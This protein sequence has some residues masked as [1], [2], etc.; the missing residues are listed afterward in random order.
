MINRKGPFGCFAIETLSENE[1]V[2]EYAMA[3]IGSNDSGCFLPCL[4]N[5]YGDIRELSFDYSGM[6]PI[7]EF[8]STG[9][10]DNK[11]PNIPS[12]GRKLGQR[13]KAVGNLLIQLITI[14][15]K[16]LPPEGLVL[17]P[18]NLYTDKDGIILKSCYRPLE[19]RMSSM[20]LSAVDINDMER[21]INTGF[22][23]DVL[24]EDEK[25][26]LLHAVATGDEDLYL[27]CCR[28]IRTTSAMRPHKD[29]LSIR[30]D[31]IIPSLTVI[32]AVYSYVSIGRK[33]AVLFA[34]AGLI[35][36]FRVI[37]LDRKDKGTKTISKQDQGQLRRKILF[38]PETTGKA[39]DNAKDL[40]YDIHY[41]SIRSVN[42]EDPDKTKS[43]SI[44]TDKV[45][46]GSD[47]FLSDI[48][49]EEE[50]VESQHAAITYDNDRYY[51]T[52]L[53]RSNTTY[54]EDKALSAG[55]SYE[56]KN[57]QK[58]TFGDQDYRFLIS[59]YGDQMTQ[60]ER[61]L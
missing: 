47:R 7:S 8:G 4:I 32:C 52:D 36:T 35:L 51:L 16:L 31:L 59:F 57:N 44:F 33:A 9:Q 18:E 58:L 30:R 39:C 26:S 38:S 15:N 43:F 40:S 11:F 6:I 20:R 14:M 27:N 46:I 29:H 45:T 17:S 23:S 60:S 10:N 5:R 3:V 13:R 2:S 55:K 12:H 28:T 56:I 53:S 48:V 22:I 19:F 42:N 54:I 21:L 41:A 61:D 24:T 49:I 50:S 25:Q 1:S 37:M 34:G